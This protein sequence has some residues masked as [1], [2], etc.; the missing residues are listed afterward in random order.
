MRLWKLNE[1]LISPEV[2]FVSGSRLVSTS[3][4]M[5]RSL[6]VRV[7]G[8]TTSQVGYNGQLPRIDISPRDGV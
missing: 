6:V 5:N 7:W 4:K 8:T 1:W 2:S 3:N